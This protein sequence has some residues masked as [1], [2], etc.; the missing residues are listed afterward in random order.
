MRE[1]GSVLSEHSPTGPFPTGI[2]PR[3][4]LGQ[5]FL[6]DSNILNRIVAASGLSGDDVALEVGPGRGALTRRLVERAGTVVAVELDPHLAAELPR[7]LSN[8][9]NLQVVTADARTVNLVDLVGDA[10]YKV[11]SNLPYY[12]ANPI[13]RH[14]LESDTPP[15]T[16]V[17]MLQK[18]VAQSI[19]ARPGRMG[20]LSVA[21]QCYAD[22]RTV[23]SVPPRAFRPPPRVSSAVVRL[24]VKPHPAIPRQEAEGFFAVVRAGFSA[25][26]K[27]L[28]NSISQ[29]LGVTGEEAGRLLAASE[30]DGTRRPGTLT[31]E[32]WV[33]VH[34]ARKGQ[35]QRARHDPRGE[36]PRRGKQSA[37]GS[38]RQG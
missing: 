25:P 34:Q 5:H 31:V 36:R 37:A 38:L 19:T 11:V 13:L 14:F 7:R 15:D 4:A 24:D 2:R 23:C 35:P 18:E 21:V 22:A 20:L 26:R 10:P 30:I 1:A 33:R 16:C 28:R 8:P 29:G 9:P 12:A 3:K 6:A 32:E 27:Q 17:L